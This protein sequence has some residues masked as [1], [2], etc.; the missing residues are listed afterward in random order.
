MFFGSG[1]DCTEGSSCF[2]GKEA[3]LLDPSL[4]R[5]GSFESFLYS[6]WTIFGCYALILTLRFVW[7]LSYIS[8][9]S[10]PSLCFA[11]WMAV[12]FF[13]SN[14]LSL[15]PKNF[16][17]WVFFKLHSKSKAYFRTV[18]VA[19]SVIDANFS[20]R[21]FRIFMILG[22]RL[23]VK[24]C[25]NF[26]TYNL[27]WGALSSRDI[28]TSSSISSRLTLCIILFK[29]TWAASTIK[30]LASLSFMKM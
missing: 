8:I 21:P 2:I 30:G 22:S 15:S 12:I 17:P 4:S 27:I 24:F 11:F 6:I 20:I 23:P 28:L 13:G 26:K 29:V 18:A 19:S 16:V 10:S 9:I 5:E 14:F 3:L 1:L 7:V 25:K